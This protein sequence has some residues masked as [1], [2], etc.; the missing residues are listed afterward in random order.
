MSQ[1]VAYL[2]V[3]TQQQHRSGLG[4]KATLA[5]KKA[6]GARLGNPKNLVVAVSIARQALVAGADTFA[7]SLLPIVR[8]LQSSGA[9]T[10]QALTNGLNERGVRSARGSRWHVSS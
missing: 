2:R 4:I 6:G 7:A 8:A 1:A 3:S 10:V 9:T 5:A